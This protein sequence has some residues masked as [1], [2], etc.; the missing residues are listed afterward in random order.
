[1]VVKYL[2]SVSGDNPDNLRGRTSM[3]YLVMDE[4]AMIDP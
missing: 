4:A 3:D 2:L 1:M